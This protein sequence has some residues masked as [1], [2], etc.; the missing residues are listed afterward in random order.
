MIRE[1]EALS[2]L[3]LADLDECFDEILT[4]EANLK[5]RLQGA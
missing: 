5:K 3:R 2:A 4:F 1:P